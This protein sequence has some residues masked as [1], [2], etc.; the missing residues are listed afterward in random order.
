MVPYSPVTF[1][2]PRALSTNV[3]P[4]IRA[5]PKRD[6]QQLLWAGGAD[7]DVAPIVVDSTR[8]GIF[9]LTAA[10]KYRPVLQEASRE[11]DIADDVELVGGASGPQSEA[12]RSN[13]AS[14][15]Q[16]HLLS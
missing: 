16:R 3:K 12:L 2:M 4:S 9:P 6:V 1:L 8:W 14:T 10:A 15:C 5:F 13:S 7:A 11:I